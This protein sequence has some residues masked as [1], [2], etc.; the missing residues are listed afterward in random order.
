MANKN[1]WN[2]QIAEKI[3]KQFKNK[4]EIVFESGFGPS[5]YPHIGTY[6]EIAR[7]KHVINALKD[8]SDKKTKYIVFTD[9]MDGLRKVP[10]GMPEML[11]EHLGKPVSR[12]PD[13]WGCCESFS[14]HMIKRI[15]SWL[16]NQGLT[17]D[18]FK[19]SH[20]A[21]ESGEFNPALTMLL[22]NYE[23]VNSII[24]PT[25]REESR[26]GWSP[27]MPVCEKCGKNLSTRVT[28]YNIDSN[29]I[30]YICDKDSEHFKSCG[31]SNEMSILDGNVKVGWKIDWA[32]RWFTF[33]VN[34]EMY[35]KDLME[36]ATLSGK[37][38]KTVF[39]GRAPMGYFY[40]MFLDDSGAKMS[41][42]VGKG[43]TLEEW[44]NMA[45]KESLDL[46]LFK[47]PQK[48]KVFSQ[49]I[50]PRYV[51]EYLDL[52]KRYYAKDP[53]ERVENDKYKDS[54]EFVAHDLT[55]N[56]P[57]EYKVSYNLLTNLIAAVGK[58]DPELIKAY[59]H[60]YEDPKPGSN[61][62]LENLISKASC[63]VKEIMLANKTSYTPTEKEALCLNNLI[64]FLGSGNHSE[65]EIQTEIFTQAKDN[66]LPPKELF[67]SVYKLLSGQSSGPR[68]GSFIHLM[69]EEEVAERLKKAME[70]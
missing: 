51:D 38:V 9:D 47:A 27:F 10:L 69:G 1:L 12:I 44:F 58:D 8:I 15:K 63:F 35:G 54:Y 42:S 56:P 28:K 6:G 21:Y 36:S 41:K 32:L 31:H 64:S 61:D 22:K 18:L 33:G 23:K 57:Y 59:V 20:E 17:Y 65:E 34:F 16:E 30:E 19:Y 62:F 66:D 67:A 4:D 45:P 5:G 48:A 24:L 13:P 46:F 25:M 2:Y 40:E 7:P 50:I 52:M 29:S 53:S 39:N 11:K 26:K 14:E 43:L 37:I 49:N 68:L 70:S 55:E 3:L 60:K